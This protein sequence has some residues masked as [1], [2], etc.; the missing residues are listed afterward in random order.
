MVEER[1]TD[2]TWPAAWWDEPM[3]PHIMVLGDG[4]GWW[5]N[6][7]FAF[8][9]RSIRELGDMCARKKITQ[10]WV[11]ASALE[12][13]GLPATLE[14]SDPRW[15]DVAAHPWTDDCGTFGA[16]RWP[17]LREWAYWYRKGGEGFH[18]NIPA[19][20]RPTWQ[21]CESAA[22]L[23][24]RVAMF[25]R[26]TGGVVWRGSPTITSDAFL[27]DRYSR[28]LAPTEL[29]P[30]MTSNAAHEV[31]MVWRR[32]PTAD[33]A[34]LRYCHALDLNLAYA[35][36]ASSLPL[37]TGEC[38]HL[39]L[40][41]FDPTM[42][43]VYFI[44][45]DAKGQWVTAP[46]MERLNAKGVHAIEA[47]VW[48]NSRRHLRPWYEMLRDARLALLEGGG[49]ALDAVKD[50]CHWGLGRMQSKKRTLAAGKVLGDDPL[51]Q[52]YWAWA[53]IAETRERNW[54]GWRG[55]PS[56]PWPSTPI[57]CSSCPTSPAREPWP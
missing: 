52:P 40:P 38:V 31:A 26:A 27:R 17:G 36:G 11:H 23:A 9:P 22:E 4:V 2:G 48:P 5:R 57:A 19:Y 56:S 1:D 21:G 39:E 18:L 42:A 55:S 30:P 16:G 33:E 43:G 6:R 7:A 37:P 8:S 54:P 51:Y 32:E 41:A 28:G 34:G 25:D 35:S 44:D 50:I 46:T 24:G 29:P 20:G 3:P 15:P 12:P 13:L 10:V 47:Y 14:P 53:V 45:D 49:P